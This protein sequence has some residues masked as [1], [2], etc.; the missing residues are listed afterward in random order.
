MYWM[1]VD[2]IGI[3]EEAVQLV[4]KILGDTPDTYKKILTAETEYKTFK[5]LEDAFIVD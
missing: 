2:N 1:L 5:E 3:S 4:L